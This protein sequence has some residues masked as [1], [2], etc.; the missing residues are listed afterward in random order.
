MNADLEYLIDSLQKEYEYLKKERDKCL[1]DF[2]Y[3]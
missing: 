2:D 1:A 3:E